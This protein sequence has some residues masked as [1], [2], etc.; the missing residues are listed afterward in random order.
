VKN[1]YYYRCVARFW[2]DAWQLDLPLAEPDLALCARNAN[3][4]AQ[5]A[6]DLQTQY[7]NIAVFL[8][9]FAI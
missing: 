3:E 2:A 4:L 9:A 5:L 7:P 6:T 8:A 1:L